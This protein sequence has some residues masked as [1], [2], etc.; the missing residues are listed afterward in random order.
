MPSLLCRRH[1]RE[2]VGRSVSPLLSL[3]LS[4]SLSRRTL[5]LDLSCSSRDPVSS[6]TPPSPLM[7]VVA[8]YL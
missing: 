4:L 1:H 5:S 8:G 3:S 6:T 7:K 2:V